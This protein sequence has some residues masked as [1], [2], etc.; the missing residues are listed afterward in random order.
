MDVL[1]VVDMQ[2]DL[3]LG[4]PKYDLAGVV[5][6]INRLARRVRDRGGAVVFIQ[7]DGGEGQ[8]FKPGT[9]GWALLSTLDRDPCDRIV[10]KT[11]NDPFHGTTL[12]Q[13]LIA[14]GAERVLISGWAT[15]FCVDACVRSAVACGF[16]VVVVS[17]AHTLADRPHLPAPRVIEHHQYIWTDLIAPSPLRLATEA[18]L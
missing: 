8:D 16:P 9:P 7:H 2:E 11:L 13:E 5:E 18:E 17:D 14:L 10:H 12:E 4:P 3:R 6:R 1:V 15:D